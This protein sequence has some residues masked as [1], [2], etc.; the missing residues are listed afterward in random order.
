VFTVATKKSSKEEI[1]NSLKKDAFPITSSKELLS[2][3]ICGPEDPICIIG[4]TPITPF[5]ISEKVKAEHFPFEDAERLTE[6]LESIY[7]AM[8]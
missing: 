5:G 3:F 8:E 4:D 6:Y 7:G 1:K 2:S